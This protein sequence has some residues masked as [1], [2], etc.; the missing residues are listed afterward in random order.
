M[1][2]STAT[3]SSLV[4]KLQREY[5][6]PSVVIHVNA[7]PPTIIESPHAAV[8]REPQGWQVEIVGE[9][10]I[11][12]CT[13]EV[14]HVVLEESGRFLEPSPPKSHQDYFMELKALVD[15]YLIETE[16]CRRDRK[17]HVEVYRQRR[18][19]RNPVE[20]FLIHGNENCIGARMYSPA[21]AILDLLSVRAVCTHV[22][23]EL[24]ESSAATFM[25]DVARSDRFDTVVATL[26]ESNFQ[27]DRA[28]YETLVKSVH[29]Q[30]TQCALK[31]RPDHTME[32]NKN[33]LNEFLR[34][35]KK[36]YT[37]VLRG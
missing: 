29:E 22:Y 3:L 19:E 35:L 36:L 4:Q 30:L 15:D 20:Y 33:D 24:S 16:M 21:S 17:T 1:D 27:I 26:G 11:P 9:P 5:K 14:L 28:G 25:R 31:F 6:I 32:Y 7:R 13:H 12:M 2:N 8:Y 10:A 37:T 23:P 18:V 34:S